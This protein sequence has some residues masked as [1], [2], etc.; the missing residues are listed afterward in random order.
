MLSPVCCMILFPTLLIPVSIPR[1]NLDHMPMAL[2]VVQVQN[3][4]IRLQYKL[5]NCRSTN[6]LRDKL[7]LHLNSPKRQL[8]FQCN[9]QTRR[10]TS[11]PDRIEKR[12]KIIVM[13][14]I[15]MIML[16][17]MTRTVEMLGGTRKINVRLSSLVSYVRTITSLT[18]A[19]VL[20]KL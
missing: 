1:S 12:V 17:V 13:V 19:L 14:G 11:S 6:L 5:A 7:R 8:Y 2:W 15:R 4:Q 10:V 9:R 18:C 16:I 3:L 20:K